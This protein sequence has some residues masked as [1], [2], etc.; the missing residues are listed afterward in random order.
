M[1]D[2]IHQGRVKPDVTA[3]FLRLNPLVLQDLLTFG[4]ELPIESRT[5]QERLRLALCLNVICHTNEK[6]SRSKTL[7]PF[8]PL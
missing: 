4:K 7:Y 6:L 3:R 1:R 8:A 5:V 2:P